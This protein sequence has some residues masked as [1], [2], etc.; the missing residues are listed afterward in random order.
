M[1]FKECFENNKVILME[2]AVGERLK[3]EY[4][5]YPDKQVALA[6]LIYRD[7]NKV[8]LKKIY[9]QYV[10]IGLKYGYPVM[11]TTPTRRANRYNVKCSDYGKNII[12]DNME[13][14]L[15]VKSNYTHPIYIGGLMGCK[16]DAYKA[17]EIL[18]EAK[19]YEFHSWQAKLFREA[20]ADYLFAGI[21]PALTE[22]VGMAI[23]MEETGL[24][25]IIS[26]MIRDNGRLIDGTP[27]SEAIEVIDKAT[28]RNPICYMTNCV[29][30]N[31][32]YKALNCSFN[33]V[34][35]V[36]KRFCG[37]QANASPMTPE[38]LESGREIIVSDY[39]E[40]ADGMIRLHQE[41]NLKI[42]GGCCGTDHIYM[43]EVA[44]GL[45]N[46]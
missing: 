24:P 29:H 43:E 3:N 23:A 1:N 44:K 45:N 5:I 37:I 39:M 7:D 16:G 4:N 26:F 27:I 17:T 35:A 20:K 9:S 6:G 30:P 34:P 40:L 18:S 33:Q 21:M 25:Y 19:A 41:Y 10:E 11:L 42:L 31:T 36:I 15:D 32:L 22:A 2:G 46:R 13:F 12:R 28:R 38:E 14:L 8:A